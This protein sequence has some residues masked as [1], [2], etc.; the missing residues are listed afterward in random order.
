[1]AEAAGRGE[2]VGHMAV[3]IGGT[4]KNCRFI[5][6][7]PSLKWMMTGGTP[8]AKEAPKWYQKY[9]VILPGTKCREKSF[10]FGAWSFCGFHPFEKG[11]RLL[12]YQMLGMLM[13]NS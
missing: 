4:P 12:S 1:M 5:R 11:M 6:E 3:S 2:L 13:S 9:L 10:M 8:M 7:N